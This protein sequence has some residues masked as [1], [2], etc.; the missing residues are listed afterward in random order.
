MFRARFRASTTFVLATLGLDALGTGLIAPIV[1]GLVQHL[2]R[3][4]PGAAA[5]WVG[6]MIAAYAG[7][8]FLLAPLLAEMSDRFGRR[9]VILLSVCG[10]GIDN[11]LM[12]FA[13]NLWWLFLGRLVAGA[14]SANVAAATA[15][16]ADVSTPEQ[17]SRRFGLVGATF[18]AGFVIGPALG[19]LLGA[20]GLR[21]PFLAAAAL[22]FLNFVFGLLVLPESLPPEKRRPIRWARANPFTLL[23]Q[24]LRDRTL[25]RL[26]V[27][28]SCSWIGLGAVQSS[29]VLFTRA[30]FGWGGELNGLLLAGV[31]LSQAVVEGLLLQ[32]AIRRLGEKRVAIAGYGLG[33]A[34]FAVLSISFAGWMMAPAVALMALGGLATPSVRAMTSGQR[35]EKHQGEMQGV[36]AAVEGFTA[37]FAPLLTA[38]LFDAAGSHGFPGAPFALAALCAVA[39]GLL[40]RGMR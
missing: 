6:A 14:T 17:R 12:V 25:T 13:P 37:I 31:G 2:S 28:W 36:L 35:D 27:A 5:P 19:G 34:G 18:G 10:L 20:H 1:P 32:P 21:L 26:A 7:M 30:R 38:A 39:A 15:Y 24:L 4:A 22:G 8:Q 33:A 16:L 29:L 3:L 11:L 23:R 9:P 40:L